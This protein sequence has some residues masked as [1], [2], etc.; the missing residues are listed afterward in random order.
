[1]KLQGFE[2]WATRLSRTAVRGLADAAQFEFTESSL[3]ADGKRLARAARFSTEGL[4]TAL[5][6]LADT[7][8]TPK[9]MVLRQTV[10]AQ[11]SAAK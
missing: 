5:A 11:E 2:I 10:G 9:N 8:P 3:G 7:C 1:M 4:T 6:S